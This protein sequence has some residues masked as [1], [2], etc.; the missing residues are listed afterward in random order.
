MNRGD[1]EPPRRLICNY[2]IEPLFY[3]LEI[4]LLLFIDSDFLKILNFSSRLNKPTITSVILL[5]LRAEFAEGTLV[6]LTVA[7]VE[8]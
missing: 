3:L 4:R 1:A 7:L 6:N 2:L 8:D 5:K